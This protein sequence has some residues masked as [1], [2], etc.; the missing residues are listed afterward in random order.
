MDRFRIA[1]FASGTGTNAEAIIKYFKSHTAIEVIML[2]SNNDQALALQRAKNLSVETRSFTREQFRES[3]VI[4]NWLKEFQI[5]HIVLAGFLWLIP[6]NLIQSFPGKIINIH[7]ALLPKFGGKG[8]YGS[9]V[10]EAVKLSGDLQT[11]ITIHEVN[12]QY[13][14]GQI[15]FQTT[16][17]VSANDSPEEI[18]HKVHQLEHAHYPQVIENWILKRATSL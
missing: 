17:E 12:D 9:K 6:K 15:L 18:A 13:D 7:P 5:T 1:I 3:D 16:C 4:I 2:L 11:G 10:H 8:M 14:E